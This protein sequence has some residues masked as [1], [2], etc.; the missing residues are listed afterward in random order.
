MVSTRNDHKIAEL[1]SC[2]QLLKR[3]RCRSPAQIGSLFLSAVYGGFE[4]GA[5]PPRPPAQPIVDTH[6]RPSTSTTN[7]P[8]HHRKLF[9]FIARIGEITPDYLTGFRYCTD[10]TRFAATY[11]RRSAAALQHLIA[12]NTGF[13]LLAGKIQIVLAA[14]DTGK[15]T[16]NR[17][18]DR[19]R[20]PFSRSRRSGSA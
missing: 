6:K 7:P 14:F 11:D 5:E 20:V 17:H 4:A 8:A 19:S 15:K 3:R 18:D 16:V 9:A 2:I 13:H 10:D 1:A 12:M